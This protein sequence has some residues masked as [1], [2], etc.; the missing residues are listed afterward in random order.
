VLGI[1]AGMMGENSA[2]VQQ[3]EEATMNGRANDKV[4]F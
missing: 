4:V 2:A 3:C 1:E